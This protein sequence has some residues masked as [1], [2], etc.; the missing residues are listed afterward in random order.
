MTVKNVVRMSV[1]AVLVCSI[2]IASYG[3]RRR[4]DRRDEGRWEYL[5]Q[6]HVDGRE[7]HDKIRVENGGSFR[8]IQLGIR[9]GAIEFHKIIVHF[10]NGADH[11]VE[12]RDR[13]AANEKTR[14]IDLP[15]DRRRIRSVEFW[16]GKTNWRRRPTVNLWGLR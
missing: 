12:V 16:Y 4:N 14:T 9:D 6:A 10:E 8:A 15:G 7:D 2:G 11:Q 1:A 5:G 13:I 3:Q